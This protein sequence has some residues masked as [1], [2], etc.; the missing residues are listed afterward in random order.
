MA[1]TKKA[2]AKKQSTKGKAKATA[3]AIPDFYFEVDSDKGAHVELSLYDRGEDKK[4]SVKLLI[5]E[6]FVI[7]CQAVV[8]DDYAFLSYPSFK[9]GEK[10]VNQAFSIDSE[11]ND[12]LN[13]A[14]TD[15]YF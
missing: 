10:F 13:D 9:A 4:D 6:T 2:A 11:L 14:I 5:D 8:M 7:Y 3:Q 1:Q 12:K 15:Y